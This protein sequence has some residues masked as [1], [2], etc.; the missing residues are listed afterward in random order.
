MADSVEAKVVISG[1]NDW[2]IVAKK[3]L[4]GLVASFAAV[5]IP[6]TVEFLQTEDLSS[7]PVWFVGAVPIIVGLLLAIQNAWIHRQKI[8]IVK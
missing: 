5:G 7:L 3:F 1:G 6:Y 2:G 8:E 4:Y